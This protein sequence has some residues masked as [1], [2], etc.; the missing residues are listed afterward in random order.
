MAYGG[1]VSVYVEDR[2]GDQGDPTFGSG[3]F[4]L[5]PD[6]DIPAHTGEARQGSNTVQIRVHAH[7]EPILDVKIA[8]EVYVGLPSLAMSPSVGTKRIDPGLTF[9]PATVAGTEPVANIA[10]GIATFPWTPSNDPTQVDGPGHRCLVVR[11]FP[12]SVPPPTDPFAV[13]TEPHEAQH[14]IEILKT[15]MLKADMSH[16]GAGIDGD[17][18]RRDS[19]TGLWWERFSTV[20]AGKLGVRYIVWAFDPSPPSAVTRALPPYTLISKEPPMQVTLEPDPKQG[21]AIDPNDLLDNGPFVEQSGL[22]HGLFT[23]DRLLAGAEVELHPSEIANLLLRFD[24]SNLKPNGAVVLHG[25]QWD[26]HGRAEGGMTVV[27]LAA[28]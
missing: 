21:N 18:R 7:D 17:P 22:G 12:Q 4:W 6:V 26:E 8:A 2:L 24:H 27:A 11:A 15:A 20:G 1:D 13:P 14:N 16:G 23:K 10:G 28:V 3:P 9:R 25:V 5:S 19:E